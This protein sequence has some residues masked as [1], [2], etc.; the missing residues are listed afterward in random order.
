MAADGSD[1]GPVTSG[2]VYDNHP[3]WSPDGTMIVFTRFEPTVDGSRGP[4]LMLVDA[5]E[6]GPP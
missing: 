2:D 3:D 5:A 4:R 6:P 1:P